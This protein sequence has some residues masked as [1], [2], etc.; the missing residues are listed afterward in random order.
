MTAATPRRLTGGQVVL[1]SSLSAQIAVFEHSLNAASK[2]AVSAVAFL[3]RPC[4]PPPARATPPPHRRQ[5][6]RR[7]GRRAV[8]TGYLTI[9]PFAPYHAALC[10]KPTPA[11]SPRALPICV[12]VH[13]RLYGRQVGGGRLQ[14]PGVQSPQQV[15]RGI[16]VCHGGLGV[17]HMPAGCAAWPDSCAQ[18]GSR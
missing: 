8:L 16:Q 15:R 12:R 13:A 7:A 2:A 5:H 3:P 14:V 4:V 17:A 11:L 9:A 10:S 1:A 18:A 6:H